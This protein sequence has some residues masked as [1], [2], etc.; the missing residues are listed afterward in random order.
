[1]A[2]EHDIDP[3]AAARRG[4]RTQIDTNALGAAVAGWHRR[5]DDRAHNVVLR[6]RTTNRAQRPLKHLTP[7][8]RRLLADLGRL[9]ADLGPKLACAV[10]LHA[11]DD[12]IL[13]ALA[14]SDRDGQ[15]WL[16]RQFAAVAAER[17]RLALVRAH[18]AGLPRHRRSAALA[19]ELGCTPHHARRLLH[20]LRLY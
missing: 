6:L 14:E 7:G 8:Q 4:R 15:R 17:E 13:D 11:S 9:L 20:K 1:M 16:L 19:K 3:V 10:L 5:D 12:E 18:V 2:G